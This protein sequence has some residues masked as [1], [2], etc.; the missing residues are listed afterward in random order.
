MKPPAL[1]ESPA[2]DVGSATASPPS[3]GGAHSHRW[4]AELELWFEY[5]DRRTRLMR[6]RHFGPLMVQSPFYPEQD[7]TC[8]VYVLHPPG[9]VAGGD[10]LHLTFHLGSDA[11]SVLTTPGA[12]KFYR[13]A[14][15]K[16]LQRCVINVAAGAICEYLPQETIVFDGATAEID[17]RVALEEGATFV[18]WD[19]IC[20]GR[21][22]ANE[23]FTTGSITQRVEIVRAGKPIWFERLHL[24]AGSPLQEA[25]YGLAGQP[26]F[27]AMVYAGPLK[28]G[29]ADLVLDATGEAGDRVFSVSQLDQAVVCRYLGRHAEEGKQLFAQAWDALR[30][31]LQLKPACLPRIWAT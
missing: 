8:H 22:A 24:R 15:G 16:G 17:T 4:K 1:T 9:G 13:S 7:G 23:R 31:A 30:T 26:V 6:R 3:L 14:T 27:G 5:A 11:R 10:E 21:P 25:A 12:T 2:F 18:G 19:F 29:L 20:L 28:G